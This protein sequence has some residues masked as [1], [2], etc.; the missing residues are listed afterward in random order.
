MNETAAC[1]MKREGR[2]EERNKKKKK[3]E[4]EDRIQENE[5]GRDHRE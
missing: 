3:K 1:E 2:K 4:G 5:R